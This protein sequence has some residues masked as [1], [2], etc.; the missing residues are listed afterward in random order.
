MRSRERGTRHT[1]RISHQLTVAGGILLLPI[2]IISSLYF[3]D[4]NREITQL[5]LQINQASLIDPLYALLK[6]VT[7]HRGVLNLYLQQPDR[8]QGQELFKQVELAGTRVTVALNQLKQSAVKADKVFVTS[9]QRV[10]ELWNA[11]LIKRKNSTLGD[12]RELFQQQKDLVKNLLMMLESLRQHGNLYAELRSTLVKYIP[13]M[14][15]DVALLYGM[16]SS[17]LIL[18][19]Q[20]RSLRE[21]RLMDMNEETVQNHLTLAL[22]DFVELRN[23]LNKT[24]VVGLEREKVVPLLY[25]L[26]S[27]VQEMED[28]VRWDVLDGNG[29]LYDTEQFM[30]E[31]THLIHALFALAAEVKQLYLHRLYL[32]LEETSNSK[33][34]VLI[35]LSV[36]VLIALF[37]AATIVRNI[38]TGVQ[39]AVERI[40]ELGEG[41]YDRH[42]SENMLRFNRTCEMSTILH[43]IERTRQNL[44]SMADQEVESREKLE[45][46][47]NFMND[48]TNNMQNGVYALDDTGKVSFV[49]PAAEQILGY[50]AEEL[51]GRSMHEIIHSHLPDG[52]FVPV[53]A[54]PVYKSLGKGKSYH[55]EH[56]WFIHKDGSMIPVEFNAAPLIGHNHIRGSVAVFNN[57]SVRLEMEKKLKSSLIE[58]EQANRAKSDF[59]ANMSHEIRTPMNAILGIGYLALQT[60]MDEKSRGYI[61]KMHQ[62]A[63]SLLTIINDILDFSKIEAGKLDL[64]KIPFRLSQ[65]M[66]GQQQLLMQKSDE[67]GLKLLIEVDKEVPDALLGDPSR[68]GQVLTNL[69]SNAIKFTEQGEVAI[70]VARVRQSEDE[71]T[72]LFSVSDQGIGMSTE[73]Q[74]ELFQPFTQVDGSISRKYGGTGLGLSI[75]RQLI[76]M[77]GGGDYCREPTRRGKHL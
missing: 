40:T 65:V 77:L 72:L 14:V 34:W 66:A 11:L 75:S 60:E 8:N 12:A 31:S 70:Q 23:V 15:E 30:G 41:H 16:S 5:E 52:T 74:K 76:E 61:N 45:E 67:K 6:E 18:S 29:E 33:N 64:E 58:A 59:L 42:I 63:K 49:N 13:L 68:I 27:A 3:S 47:K 43:S 35:A 56:D 4:R 44:Q 32:D 20:N 51:I 48:L 7:A 39:Q 73:Q 9:L 57:I 54:C 50:C 17:H 24:F 10:T 36:L 53:E 38:L 2:L 21:E 62:A 46:Q 55:I 71:I 22:R 25:E 26:V 28:L 69:T 1:W 37:L 19:S